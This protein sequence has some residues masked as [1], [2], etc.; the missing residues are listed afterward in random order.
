MK[1]AMYRRGDI[2]VD[3]VSNLVPGPGQVLV[4]TLACGICGSDIH[5][6]RHAHKFVDVAARAGIEAMNAD[7]NRDIIL[8]HEFSAEIVDFG[9]ETARSLKPGSSVCSVP[10]GITRNGPRAIGYSDELPGGFAEY[11]LLSEAF[12]LGIP[13]G[14]DPYRAALTEPMAVGWHAVNLAS[15]TQGHVPLVVGC[16]PVGLAVVAALK[17]ANITPILV[18]DYSARR[19]SLAL[20]MGAD[21]AIDPTRY[22]PY[23]EWSRIASMEAIS[24]SVGTGAKQRIC[25]VFECVGAPGVLRQILEGVPEG[26]E[27]TV[28]G[29]CMEP[30]TFEPVMA[31]Y[32]AA[33]MRFSRTYSGEEFAQVLHMIAEGSL[34]VD[35]LITSI[36][37]LD[38]VPAAFET[39]VNPGS[40]AKI[41][42]DPRK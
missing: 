14:L 37:G 40:H 29:A 8:G 11:M 16:G 19:R 35:P 3:N 12:L 36:I 6:C 24:D 4:K 33:T 38:G 21:V 9:S 17:Q 18:A 7:L 26:A 22:S 27:L 41:I 34:S 39:L 20:R 5:F 2:V 23:G 42:V 13:N 1:A 31:L 28:V 25:A 30:D 32:K 15:L 10:L